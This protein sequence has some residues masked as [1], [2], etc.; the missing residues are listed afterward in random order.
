[1]IKMLVLEV[2]PNVLFCNE[3]MAVLVADTRV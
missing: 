3:K 1:M 2:G